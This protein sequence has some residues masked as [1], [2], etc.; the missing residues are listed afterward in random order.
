MQVLVEDASGYVVTSSN[1]SVT[2][3][4]GANPSGG[5][6]GG[7]VTMAA[8]N[9]VATFSNLSITKTGTGYRLTAKDGSLTGAISGSFNVT[10]AAASKLVFTTQPGNT[11]V[12]TSISPAIGVSVE[13]AYGNVVTSNTSTVTLTLSS[14]TFTSGSNTAT[15]VASG[16]V[17]TFSNHLS[18]TKTGT[19]Y[20]LTAKDG[21]LTGA[22]SGSFNVTAAVLQ[23]AVFLTTD[24]LDSTKQ[25]LYVYGTAGN[26][27]ILVNPGSASGCVTVLFNGKSYGPFSPT[28]RIIVHGLA[29]NDYIGVSSQITLPA[30]L[31]GDD[32]NDVLV[33]GGG[34]NILFG[35]AGNDTLWGGKGRNI[36]IGGT[37]SDLL[38]GGAGDGL[39]IGGTTAYDANDQ[40]LRG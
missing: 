18:I 1:S 15:A 21:S 16:G 6:L 27:V 37:G 12:G 30:W 24:P 4:I 20:R 10:P 2:L 5:T 31:Y 19:G 23:N 26:D 14:G 13:D 3:A 9:G 25:T 40:A 28:G 32:G 33:G 38:S 22:T 29:G 7:T 35:G 36:L 17:A 8:V 39:L 11:I 34:P